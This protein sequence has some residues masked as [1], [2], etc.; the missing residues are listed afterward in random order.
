MQM[1]MG[2]RKQVSVGYVEL[3]FALSVDEPGCPFIPSPMTK[4]KP[5]GAV[6]KYNRR[7]PT[8]LRYLRK[9]AGLGLEDVAKEIGTEKSVV[10]RWENGLR[11]PAPCFW[12]GYA[13][14]LGIDV[15]ELG[16]NLFLARKL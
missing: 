4:K 9:Q 6:R 3:R 5:P 12:K 13:K 2:L 8:Q 11:L 16:R 7:A 1:R 14:C 15:G 10:F